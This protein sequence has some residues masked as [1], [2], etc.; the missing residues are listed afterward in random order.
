MRVV[1]ICENAQEVTDAFCKIHYVHRYIE[2]VLM[3]RI[4]EKGCRCEIN[5]LGDRFF[6][7][8]YGTCNAWALIFQFL[9]HYCVYVAQKYYIVQ[10]S[11]LSCEK[12]IEKKL[13]Q[14]RRSNRIKGDKVKPE[15][16]WTI[17]S[18]RISQESLSRELCSSG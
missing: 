16:S 8:F 6:F 15:K 13:R 14:L 7:F 4:S 2:D 3:N 11:R 5:N 17:W 18:W 1:S 12:Q 10:D 9:P